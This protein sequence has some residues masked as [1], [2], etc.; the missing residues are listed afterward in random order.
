MFVVF[1]FD[2]FALF[3]FL[4]VFFLFLFIP[5]NFNG[6][7]IYVSC[8]RARARHI[9]YTRSD[10]IFYWHTAKSFVSSSTICLRWLRTT[11]VFK[12]CLFKTY[13]GLSLSIPLKSLILG[14]YCIVVT[15]RILLFSRNN[16]LLFYYQNCAPPATF[17]KSAPSSTYIDCF[18]RHTTFEF[19][20]LQIWFVRASNVSYE[21][22]RANS[23]N[24]K[25]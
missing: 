5:V 1:H 7:I 19:I 18:G 16:Y 4:F 20:K 24:G 6:N 2:R 15:Y 14:I 10:V 9:W 12:L 17:R 23:E 21:T 22:F 8:L 13:F 11:M 25:D 3:S